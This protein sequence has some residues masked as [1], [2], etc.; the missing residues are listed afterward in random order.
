[1]CLPKGCYQGC[2]SF[3]PNNRP[4]F[5]HTY[6]CDPKRRGVGRSNEKL[7][8][9]YSESDFAFESLTSTL[10]KRNDKKVRRRLAIQTALSLIFSARALECAFEKHS[11]SCVGANIFYFLR[12]C[13]W[14]CRKHQF[15]HLIYPSPIW[16]NKT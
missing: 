13:T 2:Q 1:M 9:S 6:A 3:E 16:R 5:Y 4:R 7:P 14:L 12:C 10:L 11:G 8:P 15:M